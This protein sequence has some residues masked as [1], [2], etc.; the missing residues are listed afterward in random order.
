[1]HLVVVI[2]II[3]I[4]IIIRRRRRRQ[5]LKKAFLTHFVGGVGVPDDEFS[6]LRGGHEV[7]RVCAPVHRIHLQPEVCRQLFVLFETLYKCRHHHHHRNHHHRYHD[8][9]ETLDKCPRRV[10]RVLICILPIGSMLPVALK[11]TL[12]RN[13]IGMVMVMTTCAREVSQAAFLP[14]RMAFFRCSAS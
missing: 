1:M 10:L 13:M 12:E 9:D 14:S 3:T 7:A 11:G 2:M 8:E 5:S 6:V 4:I